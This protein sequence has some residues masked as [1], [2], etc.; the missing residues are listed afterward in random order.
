[1]SLHIP[2]YLPHI[3]PYLGGVVSLQADREVDDARHEALSRYFRVLSG[4]LG[5][6][7]V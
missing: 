2:P 3:S 4:S 7:G 6:R 5:R 1:M